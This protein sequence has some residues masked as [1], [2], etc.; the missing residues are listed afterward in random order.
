MGDAAKRA[1][2]GYKAAHYDRWASLSA[3]ARF[4]VTKYAGTEDAPRAEAQ[5]CGKPIHAIAFAGR[6]PKPTR[7]ELTAYYERG[8]AAEQACR[9]WL[10]ANGRPDWR[11]PAAYWEEL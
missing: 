3:C 11:D 7:E 9:D 1:S 2:I 8:D 10:V 6:G 5:D 4:S